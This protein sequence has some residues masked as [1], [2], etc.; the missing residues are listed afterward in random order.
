MISSTEVSGESTVHEGS[1]VGEGIG[2]GLENDPKK[3]GN[4]LPFARPEI[5]R[6]NPNARTTSASAKD[7]EPAKCKMRFVFILALD[8]M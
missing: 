8:F 4:G 2:V 5:A 6:L 1:G 7:R 3:G